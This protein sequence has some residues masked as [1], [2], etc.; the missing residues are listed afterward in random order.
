MGG[1]NTKLVQLLDVEY[2]YRC[3]RDARVA[4]INQELVKFRIHSNQTSKR[5]SET[6]TNDSILYPFLLV[7]NSLFFL[8]PYVTLKALYLT[9]GVF[10][11]R[12]I[13]KY[14]YK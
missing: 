11:V 2:W 8:H 14:T 5:N 1:F 13:K 6:K 9:M 7:K 12:K 4:H 3:F 10:L